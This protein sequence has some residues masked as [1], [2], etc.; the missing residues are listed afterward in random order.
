L[1]RGLVILSL[2][3]LAAA[4][5]VSCGDSGGGG[6]PGVDPGPGP[7]P[8][9][10]PP[11]VP[12]TIVILNQPTGPSFQ[13]MPPDLGGVNLEVW[14][15]DGTHGVVESADI[16]AKGFYTVPAYCDI[17]GEQGTD[18]IGKFYIAHNGSNAR[19]GELLPPGVIYLNELNIVKVPSVWYADQR[20]DYAD[21]MIQGNYQWV[22]ADPYVDS[23]GTAKFATC[24]RFR[25]YTI[26]VDQG[27]PYIELDSIG[28]KNTVKVTIA[29]GDASEKVALFAVSNY[30]VPNNIEFVYPSADVFFLFD[31]DTF[32]TRNYV[33]S[34]GTANA[35]RLLALVSSSKAQFKIHY[36]DNVERTIGWPEFLGNIEYAYKRHNSV[37]N[38]TSIFWGD[39]RTRLETGRG[40]NQNQ[41]AL[42][43][44]SEDE[45]GNNVWNFMMEYIPQ[46]FI[47]D[48][49]MTYASVFTVA[50]PVFEFSGDIVIARKP[51]LSLN[52]TTP[53]D[54]GTASTMTDDLL[55]AI[56]DRWTL[57]ASYERTGSAAKTKTIP[58]LKNMFYGSAATTSLNLTGSPT[59]SRTYSFGVLSGDKGRIPDHD[60]PLQLFYRGETSSE[61][62]EVLVDVFA[63]LP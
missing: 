11:V 48:T 16:A 61:E 15:S 3:A 38:P 45:D 46:R 4:L 19:S 26:P 14:W 18:D 54:R 31:D 12:L 17:P 7:G 23:T 56:K 10:P 60:W 63:D 57:T 49:D 62:N 6:D 27:Y 40:Q 2:F 9:P 1:R 53:W 52:I 13:G 24:N 37:L 32:D 33:G 36:T 29:K 30:Y 55:D 58:F 28:G 22:N 51:G 44:F 42:L 59:F 34:L 35:N 20:P 25:T 47:K 5:A 41:I 50:V 43:N 21:F 8:T 39:D